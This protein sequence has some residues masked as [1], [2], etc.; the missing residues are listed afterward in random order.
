MLHVIVSSDARTRMIQSAALLFR[1]RGVEATALSDVIQHSGAPRGSIYHHFPGGKAELTTAATEFAG[2]LI[3]QTIVKAADEG[4]PRV[5]VRRFVDLWRD[6]LRDSDFDAG[7]PVVA[8]AVEGERTPGARA[9]AGVAFERW[10]AL[11]AGALEGRGVA[12]DRAESLAAIVI[13][14][15]EGAIVLA[16]AQHDFKPLDRVGRELDGVLT[17]VLADADA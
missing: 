8:A 17:A 10:Q 3:A 12:T 6:V 7:C 15:I 14:G 9:A 11:F 2:D 4:D 1:E 13:A 5:A 16:R